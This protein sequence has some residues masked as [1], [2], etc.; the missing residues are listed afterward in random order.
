[1]KGKGKE[2]ERKRKG[3]GKE[4]ERK[5]KGKGRDKKEQLH[6]QIV[7]HPPDPATKTHRF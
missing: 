6:K 7:M 1:M 3:K 4:H 2:N 5:M